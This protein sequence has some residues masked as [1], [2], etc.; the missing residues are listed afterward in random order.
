MSAELCPAVFGNVGRGIR[1]RERNKFVDSSQKMNEMGAEWFA[2]FRL[3]LQLN[4]I[5]A[6]YLKKIVQL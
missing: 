3:M 1:F 4:L 5:T 2:L 6:F